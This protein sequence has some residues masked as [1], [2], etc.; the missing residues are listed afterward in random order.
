[1][2]AAP[3]GAK[4]VG[5]GCHRHSPVPAH[6]AQIIMAPLKNRTPPGAPGFAGPFPL[7]TVEESNAVAPVTSPPCP[8]VRSQSPR[9]WACLKRLHALPRNQLYLSLPSGIVSNLDGSPPPRQQKLFFLLGY[10]SGVI[11][12]FCSFCLCQI[13][14]WLLL[15]SGQSSG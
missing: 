9:R 6:H 15:S 12:M 2:V 3:Q 8:P 4:K 5:Q 1:M 13:L 11:H 14:F 7:A 10:Y